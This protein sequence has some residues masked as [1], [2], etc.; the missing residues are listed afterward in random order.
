MNDEFEYVFVVIIIIVGFIVW[1][2]SDWLS[3]CEGKGGVIDSTNKP[4]WAY[5]SL[6]VVNDWVVLLLFDGYTS[7]GKFNDSAD[8]CWYDEL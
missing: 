4:C 7:V 6:F 1:K 3:F 2:S 5:Q 8:G